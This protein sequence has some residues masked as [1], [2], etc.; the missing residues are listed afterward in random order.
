MML[1]FQNFKGTVL[2]LNFQALY[3]DSQVYFTAG[4]PGVHLVLKTD[5]VFE[6][7]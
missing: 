4:V 7:F 3:G 5:Y 1:L 2:K 6:L